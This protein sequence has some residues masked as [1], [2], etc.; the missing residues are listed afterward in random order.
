MARKILR[1]SSL[2][3]SLI[4]LQLT[5]F[6]AAG[7]CASTPELAPTPVLS[8]APTSAL[9]AG[10]PHFTPDDRLKAQVQF[11]VDIYG[12]YS[13][14]QAV[15]HDAKYIDLVYEVVDFTSSR[16]QSAS[17]P[18]AK[19]VKKKWRDA[20]LSVHRKQQKGEALTGDELTVWRLFEKINEPDKFLNAAH[21]KRLRYQLGQK[22]NF[23]DGLR[24]SSRYLPHFERVFSEAGLP[25][26]LTRLPFVESSFNLKARS[27][28]GASG[29]W[30]FMRSTG[31]LYLKI[32][33]RVDERNDPI[34]ASEAAARLLKLNYESLGRWPLA[35]TAYNHGRKGM[36]RAVRKV[37]SD[38]LEDLIESYKSRSFGFASSNFYAC[39]LA[40]IEV[41]RNA[42]KYFGPVQRDQPLR[43]VEV[44]LPTSVNFKKMAELMSLDVEPIVE[45]NPGV[46][47]SVWKGR[48]PLPARYRLRM[49][50]DGKLPPDAQARV[51]LSGFEQI[52]KVYRRF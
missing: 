47:D 5:L 45:L 13:N 9:G 39:L 26:E 24:A 8:P 4:C 16:D 19:A 14:Q 40:A 49:P 50:D 52:P 31:R 48:Q 33:D 38:S 43:F 10:N 22:N 42:E 37:G 18:R 12:K 32:N 3:R 35:V 29:I 30:Q 23:L 51:F 34:R 44:E 36:M 6:F 27:K 11:W 21:R 28:V 15:V 41:E 2:I 25:L 1:S 46:A 20:L 7:A 17:S